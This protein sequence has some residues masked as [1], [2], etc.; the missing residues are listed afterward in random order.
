[1]HPNIGIVHT[2]RHSD[3]IS[4]RPDGL[5]TLTCQFDDINDSHRDRL[6]GPVTWNPDLIWPTL[7]YAYV[8]I[9]GLST[10]QSPLALHGCFNSLPILPSGI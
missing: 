5:N 2:C 3:S 4:M 6:L 10:L 1:M 9:Y 8:Y 7:H